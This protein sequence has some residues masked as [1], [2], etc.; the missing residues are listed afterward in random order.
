MW[1]GVFVLGAAL[2]IEH[3]RP[4]GRRFL[5]CELVGRN[6]AFGPASDPTKHLL[7]H[8]EADYSD[9]L[10]QDR[11]PPPGISVSLSDEKPRCVVR[12][13]PKHEGPGE[14]LRRWDVPHRNP[15]TK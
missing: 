7:A 13:I 14:V 8:H 11:C 6:R 5:R 4:S 3:R 2:G 1:R 10:D 12:L 9:G 15:A